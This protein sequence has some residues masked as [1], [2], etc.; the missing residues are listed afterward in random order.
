MASNIEKIEEKVKQKGV[1]NINSK[2]KI[3]DDGTHSES[4]WKREFLAM[5]VWLFQEEP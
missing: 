1:L 4:Y 2:V 5:Y 3:D